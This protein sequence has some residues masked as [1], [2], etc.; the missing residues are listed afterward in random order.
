[1]KWII[2][3]RQMKKLE[4]GE[5]AY[6]KGLVSKGGKNYQGY[7][8]FDELSKRIVFSFKNPKRV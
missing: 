3:N 4:A 7:I 2:G 5:W 1:M 6:I 8:S